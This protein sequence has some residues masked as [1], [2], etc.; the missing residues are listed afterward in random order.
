MCTKLQSFQQIYFTVL[1]LVHLCD[2][3]KCLWGLYVCLKRIITNKP[4]RLINYLFSAE[5]VL[6][7]DK[8]WTWLKPVIFISTILIFFLMHAHFVNFFYIHIVFLILIWV[9]LFILNHFYG[10]FLPGK[11][12]YYENSSR[13]NLFQDFENIVL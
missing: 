10:S 11:S 8:D 2:E 6:H 5:S 13:I 1:L 3:R 9:I 7:E 4:M 12:H